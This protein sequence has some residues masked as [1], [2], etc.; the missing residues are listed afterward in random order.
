MY[1][2]SKVSSIAA[3]IKLAAFLTVLAASFSLF[4]ATT[5]NAQVTTADVVGVV[6]DNSGG[7]LSNA[8]VTMTNLG[9]NNVRTATTDNSGEYVFN[10]CRLAD[11]PCEWK[12]PVLKASSS[13]NSRSRGRPCA[14]GCE[15]GSRPDFETVNITADASVLQTDS[16]TVGTAITGKLVQEL[17]LN[18]RNYVSLLCWRWA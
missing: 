17:P 10:L 4:G 2:F 3:D 8:K 13:T 9:T 5:A 7:V 6:T 14:R 12:P 18:G 1:P 15:N 16:S 11:I